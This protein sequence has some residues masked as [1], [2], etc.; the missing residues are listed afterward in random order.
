MRFSVFQK[1]NE[2][3]K[4]LISGELVVGT[5]INTI[6]DPFIARITAGAG[7]DY[8][9]IDAEHSGATMA[10]ISNICLLARECG[11]YPIVR[12]AEPN[13]LKANGRLLD[14]GAMGIVVPHI[15]SAKQAQE[16][17]KSMR[18]FGGTRGY[19]SRSI[20]SGF[21]KISKDDLRLSDK[22]ITCIVQ[23]ESVAAIEQADE[24]L[25]IEGIDVAIVGRGDLAHDMGLS[26]KTTDE[27][28]STQVEK[29]YHSAEKYGKI[30]GLLI[31]DTSEV[32]HWLRQGISFLTFGSEVGFLQSSYKRGL[33][34]IR[35]IQKK[36]VGIK[37]EIIE[38]EGYGESTPVS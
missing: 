8:L 25:S 5:W 3:K 1:K 18:Y 19:C 7:F 13:D 6:R 38:Y 15:D 4:K 12:P 17:V 37:E 34:E 26:G 31:N 14:A 28:V 29:V 10:T 35:E 22:E 30:R 9:L 21:E 27:R 16:I 11:L 33:K 20:S 32:E 2:F 24:I 36:I 23:F